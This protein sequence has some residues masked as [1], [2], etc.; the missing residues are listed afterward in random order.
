MMQEAFLAFWNFFLT[1]AGANIVGSYYGTTRRRLLTWAQRVVLLSRE[2]L[3]HRSFPPRVTVSLDRA[4]ARNNERMSRPSSCSRK[5]TASTKGYWPLMRLFER[6][7][8]Q[9]GWLASAAC[10]NDFC[11]GTNA[12]IIN[13]HYLML[14][15]YFFPLLQMWVWSMWPPI[16]F[17]WGSWA[18]RTAHRW[19]TSAC[20]SW[21]S[22]GPTWG[23]CQWPSATGFRTVESSRWPSCATNYATWMS[24]VVRQ[25]VMMPLKRWQGPV[26]D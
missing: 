4:L 11:C 9:W 24:G 8:R 5:G 17:P 22:W 16:V 13:Q 12:L 7:G 2:R 1:I 23:T 10:Q 18:S 3:D 26:Q 25:S 14:L 21:P 19:R 6:E 15:S 20:T